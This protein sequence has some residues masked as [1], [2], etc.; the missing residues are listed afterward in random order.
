MT[1]ESQANSGNE[2][3][4]AADPGSVSNRVQAI[5]EKANQLS[6]TL[7]RIEKNLQE[8]AGESKE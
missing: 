7:D 3:Q 6:E 1:H 5:R 8:A 4:P 2:S